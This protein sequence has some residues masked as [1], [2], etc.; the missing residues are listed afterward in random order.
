MTSNNLIITKQ[1]NCDPIKLNNN[2]ENM[3]QLYNVNINCFNRQEPEK[4]NQM[5]LDDKY[6]LSLRT[7]NNS[8]KDCLINPQSS[9][10]NLQTIDISNS[11]INKKLKT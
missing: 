7:C 6:K 4:I 8:G 9:E 10:I 3:K 5:K 1:I 2:I 11:N